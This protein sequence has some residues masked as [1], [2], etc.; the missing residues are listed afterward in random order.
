MKQWNRL[1]SAVEW[2]CQLTCLNISAGLVLACTT[3]KLALRVSRPIKVNFPQNQRNPQTFSGKLLQEACSPN[4]FIFPQLTRFVL[5]SIGVWIKHWTCPLQRTYHR[6]I[7]SD[8]IALACA[9]STFKQCM[10]R[11]AVSNQNGVVET[12]DFQCKCEWTI[13]S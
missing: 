5:E 7:N 10:A 2:R 8:A 12:A 1:L 11:G 3:T 4:Q 13:L 9:A 6:P